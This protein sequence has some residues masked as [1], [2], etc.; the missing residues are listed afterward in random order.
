MTSSRT[1]LGV[2]SAAFGIGLFAVVL[3][4]WF[5]MVQ[6]EEVW[7]RRS[8]ENRWAF[9]SV[10]SQRGA[11]RDRDG[12][13]LARDVATSRIAVYYHRFRL[14]HV[15]G[16]AVH[17]ATTWANLLTERAG[18]T[19]TYLPGVLGPRVAAED[20]L[21]VPVRALQ[22]GVLSKS[23]FKDLATYATTVLSVCSGMTRAQAFTA[24]RE[25]ATS[26][27]NVGIGDVLETP[28]AE[29]LQA[30]S[31]RLAELR[32]LDGLLRAE[33]Q[34]HAERSGST[35]VGASLIDTLE[36]LR[37]RS[38]AGARSS[39]ID[40]DGVERDG[41]AYEDIRRFFAN[42]VAFELAA[43][44][45]VDRKA[46][47]GID[48]EPSVRREHL[49]G[50][51]SSIGVLIGEVRSHDRLVWK[52]DPPKEDA[53]TT[54]AP[55]AAPTPDAPSKP[56]QG[57][58]PKAKADSWVDKYLDT[59]MGDS[60]L[61]EL[62]PDDVVA[63]EYALAKMRAEAERR[64]RRDMHVFERRGIRGL[65][66]LCDDELMGVLGMRFIEHDSR[67]REQLLW[68]HLR[69][70]SGR[71]VQVTIDL[72]VQHAAEIAVRNADA[73]YRPLYTDAKDLEFLEAAVA[74]I[75][76]H[77]GDVLA[78]AGAPLRT[79]ESQVTVPGFVWR[80]NGSIGSVVKPF[81]LVE[82][83][84]AE[85][86]GL[87]HLPLAQL[88]PCH[89][90]FVY[91]NANLSCDHEHW[92]RGQ[93]PVTA[94]AK[95]CNLF[96]YQVG[97]GLGEEGLAR[98]LRRFGLLEAEAPNPFAPSWQS[99]V[100]GLHLAQARYRIGRRH[101]P[102]RAIGYGVEVSPLMVARAYAG[103]A[104]G[105]LPTV[106]LR[107]GE[108]RQR[109]SLG[110]IEGSLAVVREGMRECVETGT[111]RNL[112]RLG[113]WEVHAKTG[114]AEI[115]ARTKQNNGW[116]AGYVPW[117]GG[118]GMQLAF[119]AVVYRVPRGVHGADAAGQIVVDLLS[120]LDAD[121]QLKQRYL[122]PSDR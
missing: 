60:W 42:D 95:S 65:E 102:T 98:A 16:A 44:L 2:L 35:K 62:V 70:Q 115:S 112:D 72:D 49:G 77:S 80:S 82:Q 106:G 25:A 76:A 73:R 56:D 68:S 4:L 26:G 119:C 61:N 6:D 58:P 5:L 27:A 101:L 88:E 81:V 51:D 91:R 104:T 50:R 19:Y 28:R 86:F 23:D 14:R 67:R 90:R 15:I 84:E 71:D 11:L 1:R 85:R 47:P 75:D 3:H 66:A 64:Y 17:G 38:L 100:P 59:E 96:F 29:L 43:A 39:Y 54:P 113:E 109:V 116:F 94:L 79:V 41:S 97:V 40:K 55:G 46:H 99:R 9:R 52:E 10:P 107:L 110:D 103:L 12:V 20:L 33:Q 93:H 32:K 122:T 83:L 74:V 87:P 30:F 89:K 114:T 57:A 121:S 8:Y 63:N 31:V 37:R 7:A 36:L 34:K 13:I 69:V 48:V 78:L 105:I 111:G 120:H 18:T 92:A 21:D 45:R 22:P 118:G 53:A 108:A 117:T 24:M